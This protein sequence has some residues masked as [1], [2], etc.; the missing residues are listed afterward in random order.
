MRLLGSRWESNRF[1][2]A[3]FSRLEVF[4]S[5]I[6]GLP[7]CLYPFL[8]GGKR[9]EAGSLVRRR[10]ASTGQ[11]V[12]VPLVGRKVLGGGVGVGHVEGSGGF[13]VDFILVNYVGQN[14]PFGG[15][16][17]RVLWYRR[18][19]ATSH[20]TDTRPLPNPPVGSMWY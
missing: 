13:S 4:R 8:L 10:Y 17:L 7:G 11:E 20:N 15:I 19:Q 18:N 16:K 12:G 1:F 9:L 6:R 5:R 3:F 2:L 14:L